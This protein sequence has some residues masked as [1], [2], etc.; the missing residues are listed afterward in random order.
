[1]VDINKYKFFLFQILKEIYEDKELSEST[2]H[3]KDCI[4]SAF[5]HLIGTRS[6]KTSTNPSTS[7]LYLYH[8]L[9]SQANEKVRR[10]NNS[11]HRSS[12]RFRLC[13]SRKFSFYGS[14][15]IVDRL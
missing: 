6:A 9:K 2:A 8:Q 15:F 14:K 7:P 10:K 12:S 13:S 1:M 3:L 5:A 4:F 11:Y